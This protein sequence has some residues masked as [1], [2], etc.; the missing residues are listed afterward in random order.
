LRSVESRAWLAGSGRSGTT[1]LGQVLAAPRGNALLY[2][3]LHPGLARFSSDLTPRISDPGDRPYL[4]TDSEFPSWQR[5]IEHILGGAGF[6]RRT[7]LAGRRLSDR[8]RAVWRAL[9]GRRLVVKAIRSNLMV[10]WLAR[11][12]DLRVVLLLR[13]PCATVASQAMRGWG[14]RRRMIEVLLQQPELVQ[15]HLKDDLARIESGSV[16]GAPLTR[17][18]A[19]WAIE[20]RVALAM[21]ARDRRIF[22]VAYENLLVRPRV[23]LERIFAF[24]GW[25]PQPSDWRR[26]LSRAETR[27]GGIAPAARLARWKDQLPEGAAVDILGV[28]RSLGIDFYDEGELP[29]RPFASRSQDTADDPVSPDPAAPAQS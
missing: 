2:E 3:P 7:M 6:T 25:D 19:R 23:E 21:A 11:T 10:G 20:S 28:V 14:L 18:A 4:R 27:T 9:T 5:Y 12:F 15:D 26:V 17:L 8:P 13:H 29:I 24:L 16:L 1:W 22:P